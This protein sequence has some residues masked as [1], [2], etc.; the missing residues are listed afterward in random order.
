MR[1]NISLKGEAGKL[2]DAFVK[3]VYFFMEFEAQRILFSL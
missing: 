3:F 2:F 1:G